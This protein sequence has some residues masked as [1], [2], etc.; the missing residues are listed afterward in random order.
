MSRMKETEA[1][2]DGRTGS[3]YPCD[4]VDLILKMQTA[5]KRGDEWPELWWWLGLILFLLFLVVSSIP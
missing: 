3:D 4:V 2:G 5:G 1:V